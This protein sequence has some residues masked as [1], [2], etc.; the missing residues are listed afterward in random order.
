MPHRQWTGDPDEMPETYAMLQDMPHGESLAGQSMPPSTGWVGGPAI[1]GSPPEEEGGFVDTVT[2]VIGGVAG[3]IVGQLVESYADIKA[4]PGPVEDWVDLPFS[5][6]AEPAFGYASEIAGTAVGTVVTAATKSPTL[7]IAAGLATEL[8][9]ESMYEGSQ[10]PGPIQPSADTYD[11]F[12]P[13]EMTPMPGNGGS[14]VPYGQR[15][16]Y[17]RVNKMTGLKYGRLMNGTMVYQKKNGTISTH[18]PKRPIVLYPGR[19][20]IGQASR[21]STLLGNY[22]KRLKKSK[23]KAFL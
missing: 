20:T 8:F 10:A 7:G 9:I 17:I 19:V 15:F 14:M 21:A 12:Q 6:E 23:F 18:R 22:A 13:Q 2:G 4:G 11:V 5:G 3:Y 16:A 1:M